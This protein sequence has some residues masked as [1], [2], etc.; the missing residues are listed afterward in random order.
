M[1]IVTSTIAVVLLIVWGA[2]RAISRA[3]LRRYYEDMERVAHERDNP[4]VAFH[5]K[6]GD[7]TTRNVTTD[8]S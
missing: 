5:V 1:V 2:R 7:G 8:R 3:N 4:T 6:R